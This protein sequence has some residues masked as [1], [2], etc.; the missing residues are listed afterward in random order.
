MI[1]T[2]GQADE[3][4]VLLE[5]DDGRFWLLL[6]DLG[7]NSEGTCKIVVNIFREGLTDEV[8]NENFRRERARDQ[9]D[10]D[11]QDELPW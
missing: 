3:L 5:P 1:I 11:A 10:A 9:A 8:C 2:R 6:R 7:I 4:E